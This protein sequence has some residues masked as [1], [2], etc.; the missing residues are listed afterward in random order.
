MHG[1]TVRIE[2]EITAK[3]IGEADYKEEQFYYTGVV[4]DKNTLVTTVPIQILDYVPNNLQYYEINNSSYWSVIKPE[5]IISQGLV[6]ANL[7]ANI[8]KFNTIITSN[9]TNVALVPT[10]YTEKVDSSKQNSVSIPLVLTQLITTENKT[11]D[12]TYNNKVELVLQS[13]T[14]GRIMAY[15]VPGNQDPAGEI[16]ELDA[17]LAKVSILPPFGTTLM[18]IIIAVI[19]IAG[20][21]IIAVGIIFI[22]R[23]VLTK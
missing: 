18:Y 1:A 14:V 5:D 20:A 17:D 13:N 16:L 11:K 9:K 22:K 6:N 8:E 10:I 3:N 19:T 23:K 21:A 7:K 4:K 15:S 12:L 2:Y